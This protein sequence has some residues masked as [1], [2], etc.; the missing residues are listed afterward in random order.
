M[1]DKK[2]IDIVIKLQKDNPNLYLCGSVALITAGLLENRKVSDID[3]VLKYKDLDSIVNLIDMRIDTSYKPDRHDG[4]DSYHGYYGT[5]VAG[6][7]AI[8]LLIFKNNAPL[9]VEFI[10]YS[11]NTIKVQK[12]DDILC[13][14]KKYNRSK[15]IQDLEK[16][17]NKLIE[18]ELVN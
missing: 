15:D 14:K 3:F 9:K 7:I 13:W 12:L 16:I 10:K 1:V 8:N 2:I 4:Y 6:S 17:A 18:A 5:N 11:D